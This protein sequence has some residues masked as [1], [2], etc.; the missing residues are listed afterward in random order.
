MFYIGFWFS[1]HNF[2]HY[3]ISN[4][5]FP[6]HQKIEKITVPRVIKSLIFGGPYNIFTQQHACEALR[7]ITPNYTLKFSI[8]NTDRHTS[9]LRFSKTFLLSTTRSV[10]LLVNFKDNK[11]VRSSYSVYIHTFIHEFLSHASLPFSVVS[12]S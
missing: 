3:L 10:W 1:V 8:L 12:T 11:W 5:D 9:S 7:L 6:E 2:K 4:S